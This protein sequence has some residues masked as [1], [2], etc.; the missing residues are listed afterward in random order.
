[1]NMEML[2]AVVGGLL[3]SLAL[4]WALPHRQTRGAALTA[5]IGTAV[6]AVVWS[7]LTWLGWPFDGGWIWVVSLAAGP[8]VALGVALILPK[9]R[10]ASDEQYFSTLSRS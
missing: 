9:R 1:M 7:G 10:L 3:I 6:T 4:H 2:F 8:L 5:G